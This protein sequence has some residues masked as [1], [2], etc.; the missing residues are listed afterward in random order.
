MRLCKKVALFSMLWLTAIQSGW[1]EKAASEGSRPDQCDV[2]K[3]SGFEVFPGAA[4]EI[5]TTFLVKPGADAPLPEVQRHFIFSMVLAGLA[6]GARSPSTAQCPLFS[7]G[8][9]QTSLELRFVMVARAGEADGGMCRL[10]RCARRLSEVIQS[11]RIDQQTF[12]SATNLLARTFQVQTGASL[13]SPLTT[14]GPAANEALRHVY[15]VGFR[16]RMYA[17]HSAKDF[18]GLQLNEFSGWLE[19]QQNALRAALPN[20]PAHPLALRSNE[21]DCTSATSATLDEVSVDHHGWGRR[22]I[23]LIKNAFTMRPGELASIKNPALQA[24][25]F[26]DR[27]TSEPGFP[28]DEMSGRIQCAYFEL[29]EQER[30]LVLQGGWDPP[31]AQDMWRYAL[32]IAKAL[33][34]G[35]CLPT[36]LQILVAN[37]SGER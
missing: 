8:V 33:H 14:V 6:G 30:W 4:P 26:P 11:A 3:V 28:W 5:R 2:E 13:R 24:L 9:D 36:Q 10:S 29:G 21:E 16:E 35:K 32:G 27:P 17:D 20:E 23:I 25:C 37:F 34:G 31:S 1:V 22:S 15:P 18:E 12:S 19:G 7:W